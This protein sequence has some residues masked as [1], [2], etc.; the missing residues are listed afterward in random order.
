MPSNA[1]LREL[2]ISYFFPMLREYSLKYIFPVALRSSAV[3]GLSLNFISGNLSFMIENIL[4][5]ETT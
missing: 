1:L 4:P 3:A 2:S 5:T